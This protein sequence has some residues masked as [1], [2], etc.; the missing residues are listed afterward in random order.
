LSSSIGEFGDTNGNLASHYSYACALAG[1]AWFLASTIVSGTSMSLIGLQTELGLPFEKFSLPFQLLFSTAL[2]ASIPAGWCADRIAA[3]WLLLAGIA[4]LC[5][6]QVLSLFGQRVEYFS[7]AS[8]LD[9]LSVALLPPVAIV[10]STTIA[11]DLRGAIIGLGLTLAPVFGSLYSVFGKQ[12]GESAGWGSRSVFGVNLGVALLLGGVSLFTMRA[13]KAS[14]VSSRSKAS[15]QVFSKSESIH[16]F[17][18]AAIVI[19]LVGGLT[20]VTT[21]LADSTDAGMRQYAMQNFAAAMV[22]S[23]PMSIIGAVTV[24]FLRDKRRLWIPRLTAIATGLVVLGTSIAAASDNPFVSTYALGLVQSSGAFVF[25]SALSIIACWTPVKSCGLKVGVAAA[26][27]GLLGMLI[28]IALTKIR[29]EVSLDMYRW[30]IAGVAI[31]FGLW[32]AFHAWRAEIAIRLAA[33]QDV[34]LDTSKS[35]TA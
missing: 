14:D 35:S 12:F 18:C 30:V 13:F 25:A 21:Y 1:L 26:L 7:A 11:R 29:P 6:A 5:C 32:A 9:A 22:W 4:L 3:K 31:A 2:V 20:A 27:K 28:S 33:M 23:I 34:S 17:A 24:A 10:L 16:V 15:A 19:A 8:A